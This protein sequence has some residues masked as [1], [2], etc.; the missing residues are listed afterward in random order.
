MTPIEVRVST[1]GR[2]L[3]GVEC[4]I[5]DPETGQDL[6]DNATANLSPAAT[7]S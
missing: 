2:A 1:V 6:P 7:T 4:K 3:P 5:V